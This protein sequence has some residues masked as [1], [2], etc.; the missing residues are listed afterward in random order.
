MQRLGK[1]RDWNDARGYGFIDPQDGGGPA[2]FLHIRD[3]RQC[4]RRPENGE[5]VK[6]VPVRQPD[7]KWRATQVRRA[8]SRPLPSRPQP[9]DKRGL[10]MVLVFQAMLLLAYPCG[11]AWA[12]AQGRLPFE[13][14]F[15]LGLVNLLTYIAYALDKHAAQRGRWR[16]PEATLHLLELAGGW[17]GAVVAQQ[18]LRHKTRKPAYRLVFWTMVLL[19][20]TAL[21]AWVLRPAWG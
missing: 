13:I 3:Y 21:A 18:Q 4:G 1:V 15:G 9:A 17:P 16:I 10:P 11:V 14:S 6:Y 12:I 8:A 20:L 7:G 19:H 2:L 5:W